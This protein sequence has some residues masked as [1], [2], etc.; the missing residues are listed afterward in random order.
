MGSNTSRNTDTR[1]VLD[2]LRRVVQA[3]RESSRVAESR[4]GLSSAQLFVL[5]KLSEFSAISVNDLARLTHTH[6]SSV[7]AVVTRLVERG[8]VQ[9]LTSERDSRMLELTLT[10]A[11]ARLAKRSP[12]IAQERLARAIQSLPL[13]RRKAL[14][15][16]LSEV[17]KAVGPPAGAPRMFFEDRP[18]RKRRKPRGTQR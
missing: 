13:A 5:Q 4:F 17:A 1:Q 11:G 2:A 10:S 8:L 9:R 7:S 18:R 15:S 12:D 16:A 14:A 6:Q 3:L